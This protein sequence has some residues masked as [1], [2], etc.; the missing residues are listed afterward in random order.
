MTAHAGKPGPAPVTTRVI[1]CGAAGRDFHNFN[2]LYRDN[3]EIEVVAF[4]AAQI[5]DIDGR[6]YP[7]ELAGPRFPEGIPIFPEDELPELIHRHHVDE[8]LFSY[9]DVSFDHLMSLAS[10]VLAEGASFRLASVEK[11]M[12]DSR[13]PVISVCAV[14]TGCGKSQTS[15]AVA[16]E[17]TNRGYKVAVIRHPMPYGDLS[18]QKAQ[19]FASTE[20]FERYSCTIEEME[21]YEP[22]VKRGRVVYAGVDYAEVMRIAESEADIIL[23]D[24]GN[25][26]TPFFRSGLEIVVVDPHRP[27]HELS[28]YPGR[29]NFLRADVLVINK[30][31]SAAPEG[32]E[33]V[34]SNISAYNPGAKVVRA[35]SLVVCDRP[36]LVT[37]KRV[38]VV[39]DGPTLTHGSM[40]YGAGIVAAERLGAAEIID[41]RRF[42]VN[43]IA[44]VY[45]R[46]PEI[47]SLLPA[48]GYGKAQ[49][50]DLE[51]TLNRI[52]CDSVLIAT[53]VELDRVISIRRPVATVSY[54]LSVRGRPDI[55]EIVDCFVEN[56]PARR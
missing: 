13:L 55:A 2:V 40:K 52:P 11:T 31:D 22:H 35:D 38:V 36:E 27:G 53:P 44:G 8:V 19:R 43:T 37:G 7:P 5:P 14:R 56:M 28:Y 4:T 24:G 39:E 29:T 47:G 25:N 1:I 3:P 51:E 10:R 45:E 12:L 49:L 20:D 9:S 54:E 16:E 23:W 50:A 34:E 33:L 48:M 41:P 26:D 6:R 18:L 46:Y 30:I 15:R 21:E 17:L 32:L 42:A